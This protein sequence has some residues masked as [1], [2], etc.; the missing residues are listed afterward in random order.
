VPALAHR[1]AAGDEVPELDPQQ[2]NEAGHE[3]GRVGAP[4]V[5]TNSGI[6]ESEMIADRPAEGAPVGLL[7]IAR[8]DVLAPCMGRDVKVPLDEGRDKGV[9][10]V[11]IAE[12]ANV[13]KDD[14]S[15]QVGPA[16]IVPRRFEI[17]VLGRGDDHP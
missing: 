12:A 13:L 4:G 8:P 17:R 16:R 3:P 15:H 7:P 11:G 2:I 9:I 5:P 14:V 6:H 10:R 1:G